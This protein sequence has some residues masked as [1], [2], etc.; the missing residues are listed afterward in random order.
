MYMNFNS[1]KESNEDSIDYKNNL[2]E[3]NSSSSNYNE[4]K[5]RIIRPKKEYQL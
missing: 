4:E 1:L 2:N 5:N 3:K